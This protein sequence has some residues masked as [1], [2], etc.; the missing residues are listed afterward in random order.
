[1][2]TFGA[3]CYAEIGTLIPKSGGEFPY[4]QESFGPIPAFLFA[5]TSTVVLKPASLGMLSLTFAKYTLSQ[6]YDG[7][8]KKLLTK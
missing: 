1:L 7:K 3:L 5:W 8:Q 4:L 2:A 6:T